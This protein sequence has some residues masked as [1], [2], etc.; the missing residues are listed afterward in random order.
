VVPQ[1]PREDPLLLDEPRSALDAGLI[2]QDERASAERLLLKL[3]I[4]AATERLYLSYPRL[5]SNADGRARV[6]SFYALDV[7][8]AITGSVPDHRVLAQEAAEEAGASLGWPA[9][10]DPQRAV[11]DLEHD[12]AV[13]KPLLESRDTADVK[14]RAHY[15]LGLNAA[16]HRSI[17]SRWLR[18]KKPWSRCDGLAGAPP[19]LTPYLER[20]RLGQ[21]PFSLSALQRFATCPYQFLLAT[22]HRLE[23]WTEP[24]PLVRLDPLTRGS[25]YHAVQAEFQRE[26][27]KRGALPV[28][29]DTVR[30]AVTQLEAVLDRVA[31]EYK[32]QL[33]P[34]IERVWEDELDDLR[35]DLSIW[36]QRMAEEHEWIPELFEFSFGLSDEGRDPRS[37]KDPIRVDDR[38]ILRGSV[39]LIERH[40]QLEALRVTDHKTGK[41]RAKPDLVVGGGGTLQPVLYSMAV[42]RGLGQTVF[43]GRLYYSTTAGG[44][45]EHQILLNDYTRRQALEVL[46][47]IDR[48]IAQG[49]LVPAPAQG[50]CAWC[51]FKPVC[52]PREEERL[53]RK[54]KDRLADLT[55]L[56]GMR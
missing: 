35:R 47:I 9:P 55:A 51:D 48:A 34:A 37:L 11:D 8:R 12:L 22:I 5:D 36:V 3:G 43:A 31:A 19:A 39:D 38:F 56:R 30:E 17:T 2:R 27:Q 21:R 6:P 54:A 41:N 32:E 29:P 52:G 14:G 50:A 4:G 1:R 49:F 25:L 28:G 23:P 40:R 44:F 24:E 7:M 16:L 42:E 33:V 20:Q 15:L 10:R 45:G 46:E 18:E 53:E 13:L 26:M